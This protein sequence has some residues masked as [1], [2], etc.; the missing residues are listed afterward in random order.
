M[1]VLPDMPIRTP[2]EQRAPASLLPGRLAERR[3]PWKPGVPAGHVGGGRHEVHLHRQLHATPEASRAQDVRRIPHHQRSS[4]TSGRWR[5]SPWMLGSPRST[6]HVPSHHPDLRLFALVRS[7]SCH[8]GSSCV[9]SPPTLRPR[10]VLTATTRRRTGVRAAALPRDA[11]GHLRLRV[12]GAPL[13]ACVGA[14]ASTR[15]AP[16]S[17][18]AYTCV[19]WGS[20]GA[21]AHA[22]REER[23]P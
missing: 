11:G 8:M 12:A 5:R 21:G 7:S 14:M 13:P 6:W 20:A 17:A 2:G 19:V 23:D 10:R 1:H 4:P 9:A 15:H 22:G 18:C 16:S 3:R